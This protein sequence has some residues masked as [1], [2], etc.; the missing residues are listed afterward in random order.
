[1]LTHDRPLLGALSLV[2]LPT[3]LFF[4]ALATSPPPGP[5]APRAPIEDRWI[6]LLVENTPPP[7]PPDRTHWPDARALLR[8]VPFFDELP[9]DIDWGRPDDVVVPAPPEP[10]A[11]ILRPRV[12]D[13]LSLSQVRAVFHASERRFEQ[14]SLSANQHTLTLRLLVGADG[15]PVVAKVLD[16]GTHDDALEACVQ[17]ILFDLRFP[18][19]Q[20]VPLVIMDYPMRLMSRG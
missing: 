19:P 20:G 17:A 14:C 15:V 4:F 1:M 3:A 2:S 13:G 18:R 5:P 16:R 12:S 8:V 11:S 9:S 10:A 6:D 7:G